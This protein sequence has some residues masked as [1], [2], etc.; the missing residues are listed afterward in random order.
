VAD[1]TASGTS[2]RRRAAAASTGGRPSPLTLLALLIPVLTVAALALVRPADTPVT[3]HPPTE[4]DLDRATAVCPARLPGADDVVLGNTALVSGDVAVRVDGED[5]TE[6]LTAGVGAL[7]ER[8]EVV[9]TAQDDLAPGLVVTRG[10]SGSATVCT[11]PT[12]EQWFTGVGAAAEHASTL[13][14][15]NPDRGPA[16]ADVTVYDGSG[17][18]DVPALRGLRVPGGRSATFVLAD[19]VPS[20][21][22]LALRVSVSRG[23]LGASVVDVIDPVGRPRPV[24]EWLPA[25]AEPSESSYVVGV[26]TAPASSVAGRFLTVANPGDSEVRVDLRLAGLDSEFAP[27]GVEELR[28]GPES[29]QEIDLGRVLRGRVAEDVQAVLLEAT[30]PVTATLRTQVS[31]D[32]ALAAAGP[33]VESEAGVALPAGEKRIV[34]TGA[35][36]PGVVVLQAWDADG[37]EVVSER[38]VEVEPATATRIRLPDDA[39]MA[40]VRLGRTSAVVSVEV[41][42]R[43]LSVLPLHQLVTTGLLPD[44]RPAQR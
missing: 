41:V 9:V 26:G 30:A 4:V 15:I 1:P 17:I 21:D 37:E 35:T 36:A 29:V 28:L 22:A 3:T 44:V 16:V 8:G 24:R 10:G 23:R 20:R 40:L 5:T 12:P 6:A 42:D 7:D 32:L 25:Q 38:R 13:T 14:L 11:E 33:R 27:A 2:G 31:D 43:G 34:V 19:V 18:V 39:V